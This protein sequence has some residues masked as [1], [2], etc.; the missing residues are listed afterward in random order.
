MS[1]STPRV[2]TP[3]PHRQDGVLRRA[4]LHRDRLGDRIAVPHL[5]VEEAVGETVDVRR[6]GTVGCT[7]S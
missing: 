7:G 2:T 3:V 1:Y 5:P 6:A 4:V